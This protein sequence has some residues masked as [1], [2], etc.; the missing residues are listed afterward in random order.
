ML[1]IAC[2]KFSEYMTHFYLVASDYEQSEKSEKN[3]LI[4]NNAK[5]EF[6]R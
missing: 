5:R 4:V 6:A 1:K 3:K 2:A